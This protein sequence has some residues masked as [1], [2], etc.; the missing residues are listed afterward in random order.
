MDILQNSLGTISFVIQSL[1]DKFIFWLL[2][3]GSIYILFKIY[4]KSWRQLAL[5][6]GTLSFYAAVI[7]PIMNWK[8]GAYKCIAQGDKITRGGL[9]FCR[10]GMYAW[11]GENLWQWAFG[12]GIALIFLG[13]FY[14]NRDSY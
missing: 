3:A 8:S 10:E 4:S 11:Y 6:T 14:I 5:M 7:V 1:R 12:I 2:L 13:Y 9:D